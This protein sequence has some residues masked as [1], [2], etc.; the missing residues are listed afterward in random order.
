MPGVASD[1]IVSAWSTLGRSFDAS[2]ASV[3]R[4]AEAGKTAQSF[5]QGEFE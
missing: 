2:N 5:A 3:V 4:V 1:V